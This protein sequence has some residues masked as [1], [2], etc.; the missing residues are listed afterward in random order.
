MQAI[1]LSHSTTQEIAING[2]LEAPFGYRETDGHGLGACKVPN[3]KRK[4]KKM[5]ALLKNTVK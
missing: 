1:S 3:L 5:G 2:L 4:F